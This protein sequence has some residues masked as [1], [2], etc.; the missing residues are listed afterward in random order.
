MRKKEGKN[1]CIFI[2]A[3]LLLGLSIP[4]SI[5]S[6]IL[7]FAWDS[8]LSGEFYK[9]VF[10]RDGKLYELNMQGSSVAFDNNGSGEGNHLYLNSMY[11]LSELIALS[12]GD[13][14]V[15]KTDNPYFVGAIA[16]RNNKYHEQETKYRNPK[17]SYQAYRYYDENR[18][19]IFTYEPEMQSEYVVKLRPTFPAFSKRKY[20]IGNKRDYVDAT[21]LLN[22]KLNKNL[23]IKTDEMSKLLI[24]RFVNS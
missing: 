16:I 4:F 2:I 7:F 24:I 12:Y 17:D 11:S 21:K 8:Q 14:D 23:K 19:L 5:L 22:E 20:N 1:G 10:E 3:A 18:N 15:N 9:I 6:Y 13:Y